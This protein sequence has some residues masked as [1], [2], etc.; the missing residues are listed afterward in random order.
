MRPQVKASLPEGTKVVFWFFCEDQVTEIVR[1]IAEKWSALSAEEK[2]PYV[3]LAE[4]DKIRYSQQIN[5]YDGP[6]HIPVSKK[7]GKQ[8]KFPVSVGSWRN[9]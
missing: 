4:D 8:N 3:K 5:A 1:V 6:L 2:A 7:R 9:R